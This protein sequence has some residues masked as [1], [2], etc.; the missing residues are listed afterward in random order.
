MSRA[1]EQD[2]M[3]KVKLA[4]LGCGAISGY[5][6]SGI[7]TTKGLDRKVQVTAAIDLDPA[8]AARVAKQTGA[9]VFTSLPEALANGDFNA[10]DIMLPH[11][12]HEE[13][14]V[15][16]FRASKHVLLEKPMAPTLAACERILDEAE[17]YGMVF[18]VAENAEYWPEI[19]KTTELIERGL[20]G[21]VI[22]ARG[23]LWIRRD[24]AMGFE[25]PDVWRFKKDRSGGGVAIDG[26]SHW[27]RPLRIWMGEIDEVIAL[28]GNP[29]EEMEGESLFRSLIKFESGKT[30]SLDALIA[31]S[32]IAPE[33]WWKITGTDGEI[34][35]PDRGGVKIYD[36]LHPRGK[37][38]MKPQSYPA[39]Y[40]PEIED[41]A[42]AILTGKTPAASAE[43]SLGELR[44]ALAMYRSIENKK[45][46]KVWD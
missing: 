26:G 11:D 41:F 7:L 3:S 46:E 6:L 27:I 32:V 24:Q 16:S 15:A 13:A 18:M 4:F 45:W 2:N 12:L 22:T 42:D 40:G 19:V 44:T 1:P 36:G 10:V 28:A 20:I 38:V 29:I 5:H 17:A 23:S 39:S 25:S 14:A 33:Y 30:A 37:I 31:N 43:Y 34:V 9:Q 21:E 8:K 35:L